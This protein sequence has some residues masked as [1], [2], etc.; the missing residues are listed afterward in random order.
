MSQSAEKDVRPSWVPKGGEC[1]EHGSYSIGPDCPKCVA[2]V[3]AWT[4]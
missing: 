2:E 4:S 1:S 3:L